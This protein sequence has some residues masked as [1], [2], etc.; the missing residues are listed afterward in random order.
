MPKQKQKNDLVHQPVLTKEVIGCLGPKPG[1]SYLDLTAGYGGHAAAVIKATG[2]PELATLVDRDLAATK[3]L[4]E[5]FK[6]SGAHI[7][8]SDFLSTLQALVS[9]NQGFDMI[10]A[11]LGVSSPHLEQAQRGF[12]FNL[13][14]PLDMRMDQSQQL[15]ADNI[16][17]HL[18]EAELAEIFRKYGEEPKSRSIARAIVAKRPVKSTEELAAIIS[19]AV[20]WRGRRGKIHPATRGFQA[21]RIAVN[22]ELAQLEQGL[23]LTL[24]LLKPGGRLAI[25]SFHSLED[26]IVKQFMA[27]H[28]GKTLDAELNLLTKKPI[29][30]SKTEIAS[31][32]RA[33]SAK[34]RAAAKK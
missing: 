25:I 29:T 7:V 33:R 10:L 21:I 14:G 12:S 34:L 24:E 22:D 15:S 11:D 9:E 30:A 2:S 5:R 6:G 28:A 16:V 27:E 20:G 3:S 26:R 31:N 23:P 1:Q 13:P 4:K 8:Q 19:N 17:N 32:P 18:P